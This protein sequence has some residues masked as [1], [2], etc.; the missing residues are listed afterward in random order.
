M[1]QPTG[2]TESVMDSFFAP[3][4]ISDVGVLQLQSTELE[5]ADCHVLPP[6][7]P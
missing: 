2:H 4:Q 5:L 6:D 1:G 3:E 7:M